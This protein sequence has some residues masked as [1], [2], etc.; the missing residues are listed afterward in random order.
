VSDSNGELIVPMQDE[1]SV[2]G[3]L[4]G[5]EEP[6]TDLLVDLSAGGGEC[7][8]VIVSR[9]PQIEDGGHD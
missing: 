4:S 6:S 1:S 2:T 8:D 7:A 5:M 9:P 3:A